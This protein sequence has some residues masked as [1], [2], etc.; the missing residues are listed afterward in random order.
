M[1]KFGSSFMMKSPIKKHGEQ[2]R[3]RAKRLSKKVEQG[4]YD[5]ENP[6]VNKL[7]EKAEK[8]DKEHKSPLNQYY[9]KSDFFGGEINIQDLS[10]VGRLA[11]KAIDSIGKK[12]KKDSEDDTSYSDNTAMSSHV[13]DYLKDSRAKLALPV[14]S[15]VRLPDLS[16]YF[17]DK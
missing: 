8:A 9:D 16:T 2:Y 5:R 15:G 7:L 11:G 1:G 3:E 14:T 12:K 4:D 10:N 17:E 13:G 6:K